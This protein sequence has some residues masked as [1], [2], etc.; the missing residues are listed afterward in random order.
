MHVAS[1]FMLSR[2]DRVRN[3][4]CLLQGYRLNDYIAREKPTRISSKYG[5][6]NYEKIKRKSGLVNAQMRS[7][8]STVPKWSTTQSYKC[9]GLALPLSKRL[10]ASWGY[11][12][13]L[14]VC[15]DNL[16][17]VTLATKKA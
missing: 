11:W 16:S 10:E 14:Q 9:R 7:L 15:S 3:V 4:Y 1:G 17:F 12:S 2:G 6:H 5:E 8:R 13:R